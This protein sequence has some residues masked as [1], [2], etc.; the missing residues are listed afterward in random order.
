[1]AYGYAKKGA[2]LVI[3]DIRE[4]KLQKVAERARVLGSPQ[5]L[6]IRADISNINDCKRFVDEAV[7]H[8]GRC[9]LN[10][11]SNITRNN[12]NTKC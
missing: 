7:C 5:V 12:Q 3:V 8:F 11:V 10:L 9:K 1:M 6:P 2:S 4:R